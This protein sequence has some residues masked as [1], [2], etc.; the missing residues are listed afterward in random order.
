MQPAGSSYGQSVY[1][2]L[3]A[4]PLRPELNNGRVRRRERSQRPRTGVGTVCWSCSYIS[5]QTSVCRHCNTTCNE[6]SLA[7]NHNLNQVNQWT[8]DVQYTAAA[9]NLTTSAISVDF[10]DKQTQWK[11][12]WGGRSCE[13]TFSFCWIS[14]K[15]LSW[16]R[17]STENC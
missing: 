10:Q 4:A 8:M 2:D 14:Q 16:V 9:A 1:Y 3:E 12:L 5:A 7:S 13:K 6:D 11:R 17:D 15:K